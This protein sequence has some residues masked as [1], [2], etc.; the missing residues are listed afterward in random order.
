MIA[1]GDIYGDGFGK[2]VIEILERRGRL[3][4]WR[5]LCRGSCLFEIPS[6]KPCNDGIVLFLH[7]GG[8]IPYSC[9]NALNGHTGK[10]C[11]TMLYKQ[12][13]EN[14][15]A[16]ASNPTPRGLASPRRGYY[17]SLFLSPSLEA[18]QTEDDLKKYRR[19][20]GSIGTEIGNEDKQNTT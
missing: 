14:M 5:V 7:P 6:G 20:L 1:C 10:S 18:V 9:L 17:S 3:K 8:P 11:Y 4:R 13:T 15:V 2:L 19:A 12:T 16:G